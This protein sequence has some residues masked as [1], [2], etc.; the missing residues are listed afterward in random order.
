MGR[1]AAPREPRDS[2]GQPKPM[3]TR[4]R[5]RC[6]FA[7][8]SPRFQPSGQRRGGNPP[9]FEVC[10]RERRSAC[11]KSGYC[12]I[13]MPVARVTH[14]HSRDRQATHQPS[15]ALPRPLLGGPG[16]AW[17]RERLGIFRPTKRQ[18]AGRRCHASWTHLTG[19]DARAVCSARHVPLPVEILLRRHCVVQPAY[20]CTG[21]GRRPDF[22]DES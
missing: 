9:Q 11:G 2:S 13:D 7:I 14:S 5:R 6:C 3:K 17:G 16:S 15:E 18:S 1:T 19:A 12:R 8:S 10:S 4:L 21:R 22:C 20:A